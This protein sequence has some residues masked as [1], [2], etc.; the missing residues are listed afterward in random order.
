LQCFYFQTEKKKLWILV[1]SNITIKTI[2]RILIL[3]KLLLLQQFLLSFHKY[4]ILII[5]KSLLLQQFL[6]QVMYTLV[7]FIVHGVGLDLCWSWFWYLW[8]DRRNCWSNNDCRI[9]NILYLWDDRRNCWS[10]AHHSIS[11]C[12]SRYEA[13]LAV[14]VV[15]YISNPMG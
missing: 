7:C 5:R 6:T 11:R 1:I 15:S 9:I 13:D 14:S 8:D 2:F 3:R 12:M 10:N 4:R